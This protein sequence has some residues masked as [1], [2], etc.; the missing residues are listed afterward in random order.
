[1][2]G[3]ADIAF[4]ETP[5]AKP[6]NSIGT[7]GAGFEAFIITGTEVDRSQLA[8]R[9][10]K[11]LE[12]EKQAVS[13]LAAKLSNVNF[14]AHAPAEVVKAEKEKLH[15]AERRIEKFTLYLSDLV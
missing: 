5:A 11:E 2:A 6:A 15:E 7:V 14:T 3:L 10:T 8:A 4:I 1:M 12:K 9:F 13:R